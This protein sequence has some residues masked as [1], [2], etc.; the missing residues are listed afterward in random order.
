M[1][2]AP[3]IGITA[4][5][6]RGQ[7]MTFLNRLA[8][9]RAGGRSVV[10]R[11][12]GPEVP[13]DSLDGL[14]IGGGD[15]ID[16]GLYDG[17]ITL[18]VRIDPERDRLELDALAVAA[19]RGVPVLGI[20][21]GSQM[22]NVFYGGSLHQEVKEAF[23]DARTRRTVLPR[24][25]VRTRAGTRLAGIL[26]TDACQVNSLHHQA[27]D[28]LGHGFAVAAED[29]HGMIQAIEA[30]EPPAGFLLGVQ[31]HP[32][33]LFWQPRQQRLFRELVAAARAARTAGDGLASEAAP[34]H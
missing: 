16:A 1:S 30:A 34:G 12:G 2:R 33:F 6:R 7:I 25:R 9:W 10:L 26:G 4:S 11:P 29:E 5:R 23:P 13:F 20:C 15:D 3:R 24:T 28:R 32:E 31:W 21:R 17:E 14:V 8:V 27:V 22:M 18:D 19:R